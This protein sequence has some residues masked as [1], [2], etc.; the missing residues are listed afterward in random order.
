MLAA[1][2]AAHAETAEQRGFQVFR[3]VCGAC[4]G[5]KYVTYSDLSGLGVPE[6][7]IK[8]YAGQ[9]QVPDGVDDDGDPKT[10]PARLSDT[11]ASPYP[12]EALGRMANHGALPPDLSRRA[13]IEPGGIAHFLTGYGAPADGSKP[14]GIVPPGAYYNAALGKVVAMPPPL[15]DGQIAYADGTK[16]SAREAAGNV[17]AFLD[18]TARPHLRA[19]HRAGAFVLAYLAV[20]TLLLFILKKRTWKSVR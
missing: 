14:P 2:A 15:H 1:P 9:H 5:L 12:T 17:A 18:W 11:I 10:R 16:A 3:Q 7:E 13:L 20:M 19:R 8:A 6:A 4:H